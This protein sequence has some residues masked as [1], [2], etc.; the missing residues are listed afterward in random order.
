M[1]DITVTLKYTAPEEVLQELNEAL[2]RVHGGDDEYEGLTAKQQLTKD[3][4]DYLKS[5][6]YRYR[7]QMAAVDS[8]VQIEGVE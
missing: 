5:I 4:K 6:V 2:D 3:I 1:A 7:R 8:D